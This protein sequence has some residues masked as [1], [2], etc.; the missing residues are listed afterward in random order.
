MNLLAPLALKAFNH[1]LEQTPSAQAGLARHA[2]KSLRLHGGLFD[3]DIAVTADGAFT[4]TATE[5]PDAT[6]RLD[7]ALLINLPVSGRA[8]F[9]SLQTAGDADLLA[10]VNRAFQTLQWDMEADLAPLVGNMAAHRL[11]SGTQ[12]LGNLARQGIES[13]AATLAEFLTEEQPMLANRPQAEEFYRKVDTLRDDTAR[14]V[15][16][17]KRLESAP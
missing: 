2:G 15:A 10:E 17:L 5:N 11:A 16:R 6:I 8:A 4:D 13:M 7:P 14:L 9:R 1:L 3:L 12:A